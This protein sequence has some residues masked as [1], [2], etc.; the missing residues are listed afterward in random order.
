MSKIDNLELKFQLTN[1]FLRNGGDEKIGDRNLLK[2]MINI[3]YDGEMKV[4]EDSIGPRLRSFMSMILFNHSKELPALENSISEYDSFLQKSCFFEQE[5]INTEDE[6]ENFYQQYQ[7]SEAVL[8]RG[9]REASWRLTNS[10]QRNWILKS[11]KDEEKS[12]ITLL[13]KMIENG[14]E[15]YGDIITEILNKNHIDTMN[16]VAVLGFL[17][18]HSCPTSLLDWTYSL[19]NAL[20]FGIDGLIPNNNVKEIKDYFS[21]YYLDE[22]HFKNVNYKE[23]IAESMENIGTDVKEKLI[24]ELAKDEKEKNEMIEKFKNRSIWDSKKFEGSGLVDGMT[25]LEKIK[26]IPIA[27]F[28]DNN[29]ESGI[30]FSL[31]NSKNIKNQKGV[32]TWNYSPF[33]PLEVVALESHR[34]N[35]DSEGTSNYRFCKCININKNLEQFI[36]DRLTKKGII[37]D[38]IYP[39][40]DIDTWNIFERSLEKS[41][42]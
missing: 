20:Y 18:H 25:N 30:I 6:F 23:L 11:L 7:K 5:I 29:V 21:I 4:I 8:F 3:R 40:E 33:K 15:E 1:E 27:F 36:R 35:K 24:S 17:Q 28:S 39:T 16:D 12:Y 9:Q 19:D 22:N 13:K 2:E 37:K 26:M 10:L 42:L 41:K 38:F 32:F 31:S 14:K 34:E